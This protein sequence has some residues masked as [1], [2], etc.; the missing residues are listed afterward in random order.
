MYIKSIKKRTCIK[1]IKNVR[2]ICIDIKRST[3][4][5]K[6]ER[7][8]KVYILIRLTV[9]TKTKRRCITNNI[10][11][12]KKNFLLLHMTMVL[13]A[14]MDFHTTMKASFLIVM[15]FFF[16]CEKSMD[17]YEKVQTKMQTMNFHK[18]KAS[19]TFHEKNK[20]SFLWKQVQFFRRRRKQSFLLQC[21][22]KHVQVFI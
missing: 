19:P 15:I 12:N 21:I 4:I 11:M 2:R 10:S 9:N 14:S 8:S 18:K 5:K 6:K 3:H 13:E 22:L 20:Q 7:I 17:F 16:F 1:R